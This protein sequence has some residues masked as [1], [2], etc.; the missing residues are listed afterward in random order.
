MKG[1]TIRYAIFILLSVFLSGNISF[2]QIS[3]DE[4]LHRLLEGNKR[5]LSGKL[6]EKDFKQDRCRQIAG[7]NPYAIILSCAD[8]RVP[9]EI[10]FDEELGELFVI[11][12]A[13][14]VIDDVTLGS[15]EYAAGH[16][17][18]PLLLIMGHTSCGAVKAA[19]D[20]GR[21]SKGVESIASR[22]RPAVNKARTQANGE[23][24]QLE[25]AVKN[26]VVDQLKECIRASG[27][28]K[29]LEHAGKLK[30]VGGLYNIGNGRF[31]L[32]K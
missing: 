28:L 32:L 14:N 24:K 8:S 16:L 17:K 11:R 15:I 20:G 5:Y 19:F 30:I 2:G 7:Q 9:P 1:K 3:G 27:E 25:Q 10:I 31:S 4:S 18:V 13:G 21:F 23:Q 6:K 12:V 29:E 22:I 26:N